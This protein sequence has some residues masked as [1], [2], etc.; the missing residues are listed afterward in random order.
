MLKRLRLRVLRVDP[1]GV[2]D[3]PIVRP[4]LLLAQQ[5]PRPVATPTNHQLVA[6]SPDSA[7]IAAASQERKVR[8]WDAPSS[9]IHGQRELAQLERKDSP[10]AR[11]EER[12]VRRQ[13]TRMRRTRERDRPEED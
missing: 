12:K 9:A 5:M 10:H 11:S 4:A 13:R 3:F 8:V 6:I 1:S 2:S 7:R